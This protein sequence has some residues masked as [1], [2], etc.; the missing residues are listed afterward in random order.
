MQA[1]YHTLNDLFAQLGLRSDDRAIEEF[2][3][4]H[5]LDGED[6]LFHARFWNESQRKFLHDAILE[7]SDWCEVVDELDALLRH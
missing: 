5:H 3:G 7:D 1:G 2:L 4:K 6:K